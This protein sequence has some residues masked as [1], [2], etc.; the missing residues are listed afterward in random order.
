[1]PLDLAEYVA[2]GGPAKE[3]LEIWIREKVEQGGSILDYYP[4]LPE[5]EAEYERETGHKVKH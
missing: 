2:A 3:H 5:K 4:P 1:M